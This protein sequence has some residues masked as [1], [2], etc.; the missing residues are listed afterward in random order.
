MKFIC[1]KTMLA[2]AISVASRTVCQKSSIAALEGILLKAEDRLYL[3]GYNLETGITVQLDAEIQSA[4]DCIMPARLFFDIIRKLP[5]DF[6][7]IEV[8]EKYKV[9]IKGGVSSFTIMA[10]SAEDFPALPRLNEASAVRMPEKALRE[11][12]GGTIFA[13]SAERSPG[14]GNGNSPQYSCLENPTD[15]GAWQATVHGVAQSMGLQRVRHKCVFPSSLSAALPA[16][17]LSGLYVHRAGSIPQ[18]PV[19]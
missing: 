2:N 1:E 19:P 5:D 3:T 12:I 11:L 17:E 6:V 4:G 7:T 14:K 9:S 15:G 13:V 18:S 10:S 16:G 8:D